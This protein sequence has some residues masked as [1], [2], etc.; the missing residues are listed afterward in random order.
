[1]P[2]ARRSARLRVNF[3]VRSPIM[4]DDDI[5]SDGPP[6][7]KTPRESTG[8][9]FTVQ[10]YND[11]GLTDVLVNYLSTHPAD[12]RILFY[13]D[14]KKS[15]AATGA[16][17]P[18]GSDKGQIYG[19]L[20][21]IIFTDH[22]KYSAAYSSNPKKFR[23]A[24]GSRITT[25]VLFLRNKYKKVKASFGS[26]G[27]GVMPT[28]GSQ[29]KNLLDAALLE[30]PWYKDLDTIWHSNPSMA[31]T[32]HL[33]KPGVDHAGA[34]YSLVQSNSGAGSFTYFGATQ[35]PLHPPNVQPLHPPNIQP[36]HPPNL[37]YP[38]PLH[39]A[40]PVPP[41]AN[42][43]AGSQRLGDP[44]EDDDMILDD[45]SPVAGKK[46]QLPSMPSPPPNVPEPF[47]V[48]AK[49]PAS[50][51]NSRSAF[52]AQ[53]P[54]SHGSRRRLPSE[55]SCS[56]STPSST[57][58]NT[59]SSSDFHMSPTPET[60]LPNS[61]GS[62]KKKKV[63]SDVSQQVGQVRDEIESMHSDTMSRHDSKHLHFLAKLEVKSEHSRDTK[64]YEWLRSN[65]EH[66]ASQATVTHQH[67]QEVKTTE[68]RLCETDI[69]V[70]QAHSEVLDKEAETLR[71]KIQFHQMMQAS[72]VALDGGVG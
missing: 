42:I 29:A 41:N 1:M 44:A 34:L 46:R 48:P 43:L 23:D 50:A 63:K 53:K 49:T 32:T 10:W 30:L 22:P 37:S 61:A 51:Y 65:R 54:S 8:P 52:R 7:S 66:E 13:S 3:L 27:A 11:H 19:G 5:T 72:K 40:P 2:P 58:R 14:G 24:V 18:L 36:L 56:A 4:D 64:K 25:H 15:M 45:A 55:M 6:R 28:E 26:T 20:A 47:E 35:Q 21:K 33:S 59:T 69:R 38:A 68:I 31:A 39:Y 71:L 17:S 57:T 60:S 9:R 67:M 70:H 12:C 16:D 62:S